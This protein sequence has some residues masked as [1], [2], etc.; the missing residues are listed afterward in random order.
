MCTLKQLLKIKQTHINIWF[1][2]ELILP[3]LQTNSSIFKVHCFW[4]KVN[5]D[6][7]LKLYN[8]KLCKHQATWREINVNVEVKIKKRFRY[9]VWIEG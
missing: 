6:G 1:K 4:Q 3:K 5:T 2:E 8:Q 9:L 7:S